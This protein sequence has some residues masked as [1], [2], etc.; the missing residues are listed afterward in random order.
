MFNY[1]YE[2]DKFTS[3]LSSI[4][5]FNKIRRQREIDDEEEKAKALK[6][7]YKNR[8]FEERPPYAMPCWG[9][10]LVNPRTQDPTDSI[11]V[12]LSFAL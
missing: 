11:G 1:E 4:E 6:P 3:F 7:Y 2:F 9:N 8:K 5:E 10:M 12:K